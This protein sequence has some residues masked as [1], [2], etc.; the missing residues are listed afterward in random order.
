MSSSACLLRSSSM[1]PHS[2]AAMLLLQRSNTLYSNL[3]KFTGSL[4]TASS[5]HTTRSN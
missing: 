2:K 1:R 4:A 5:L 3:S